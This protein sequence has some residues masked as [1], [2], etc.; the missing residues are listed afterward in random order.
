M[1]WLCESHSC[2]N[3]YYNN[4]PYT[5]QTQYLL[6]VNF[7][8]L[9]WPMLRVQ[10]HNIHKIKIHIK[11]HMYT[12]ILYHIS[13]LSTYKHNNS[14]EYCAITK[15]RRGIYLLSCSRFNEPLT[16]NQVHGIKSQLASKSFLFTITMYIYIQ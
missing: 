11:I 3:S 15:W 7:S 10:S 1:E 4:T 16:S 14:N 8:L 12:A 13:V 5:P 9:L 6:L 2:N